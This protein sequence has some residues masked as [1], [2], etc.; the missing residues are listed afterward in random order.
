MLCVEEV[1]KGLTRYRV[2]EKLGS[3]GMGIVYKADDLQL[4]RTVAIKVLTKKEQDEPGA[5]L[6]FLREARAASQIN[7]PNIVT[8]HE[9][10]ESNE[11]TYI[12]MEYVEGRSL[13]HFILTRSLK[14]EAV[15]EIARQIC[16]ALAE[17][18]SR[19][20]IHRDVKPEN[21]LVTE[22]GLVKVLDFGLAKAFGRYD[23][24]LRGGPSMI[25]S[26][27]ESGTVMGTLSYMSPEQLRGHQLDE[28]TDIFS[29][30][31]MLYEVIMGR[32][33]FSG[34]NP[35]EIAASI[36]KD[37]AEKIDKLPEGYP[38]W[39]DGVVMRCL[40]RNRERRYASFAEVKK[41][42]LTRADQ[43][44]EQTVALTLTTGNLTESSTV[45]RL[46]RS[47][48]PTILVLPLEAVGSA[49]DSSYIGVGLAH[50]II[51]DLAKIGGL[52]VLSKA[53][54]AGR[55]DQLQTG[56]HNL[57]R[58]LGATILLEG[59]VMRSGNLIGIMAR[60]TDAETGRVIWGAQYRGDVSDLFSIQ[61]AVCESVA[62][63]LKVSI[64][65]EVRD[66]IA[67]PATKNMDAFELYSKGRAFLE[68]RDVKE[69]IDSAIQ[70]FEEALRLD[71]DFA[72]A[73]AGLG[74]AYW[75]KYLATRDAVWVERA[76]AAGD[77]ALVLD[78]YQAQ[79]H[80]SLGIVY[81][82]T[83]K[84]ERAIEEFKR[85]IELQPVSDDPYRWLG[86]CYMQKGEMKQAI[87]FFERAI[88]V[89]PGYWDNYN[90]LGICYY[91]FG[92][93]RDA[94]DQFR[95]VISIQPDNYQGYDKL[96]S[97]YSAMGL[98][99]D[100]LP[101]HE[102]AI[103]I[104]PNPESYSNIGTAFFYLGR[105][106][107]AIRAYRSAIELSPQD[108][109]LYRNLGDAYLRVGKPVEAEQ[110]YERAGKLLQSRL[111]INP[112][113]APSLGD[114]AVCH[115]KLNRKQ[116]ASDAIERAASLEPR[117][118]DLMYL[119]AVVYALTGETRKAAESLKRA[120]AH[121]YSRSEASRD[122]DLELLR[123]SAEYKLLFDGRDQ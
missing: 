117:N 82:G 50:A 10:G 99:E 107:E 85:A 112:D 77:R 81:H 22:R 45:A 64:S 101:M 109:I 61:D 5:G 39:I 71:P 7:H 63:A 93:Y 90:A 28:R 37:R 54:G 13:R 29:F 38:A 114:L 79:V 91:V 56:A 36:I 43:T 53:A 49:A 33:P 121:G 67:R 100:A 83:G 48:P 19:G 104:Y 62:A 111:A 69:N 95:R 73:Q 74:E 26:L 92:R 75:R 72:L 110:Q 12:V 105:F 11:N 1:L 4:L 68:R 24:G 65:N 70:V 6:R 97:M 76:I 118:I 3:G 86:R 98:Y 102:R 60:L 119:C 15:I 87:A 31:I 78:P 16:D 113:D 9:V 88:E 59:E 66:L 20:V 27:T 21:I 84:V 23:S 55:I 94:A 58:Q 35:F 34:D 41:E 115:A 103:E 46:K 47:S 52:S 106:E 44:L 108:D 18:H 123:E 14:P 80:V 30:G 42:L 2:I 32:L 40:E 116:E 25:D 120:L 51:T 122:P 8:I 17:A 57:A 96:G 89:Q